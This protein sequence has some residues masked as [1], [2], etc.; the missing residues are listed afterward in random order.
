[1][2]NFFKSWCMKLDFFYSYSHIKKECGMNQSAFLVWFLVLFFGWLVGF[3]CLLVSD[4]IAA[5]SR[6]WQAFGRVTHLWPIFPTCRWTLTTTAHGVKEK[7][8]GSSHSRIHLFTGKHP[9]LTGNYL[10]HFTRTL[11]LCWIICLI[12]QTAE[13]RK[14]LHTQVAN[15]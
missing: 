11:T 13:P 4:K 6:V 8:D 9:L 14:F 10:L 15:I 12:Y 1:M 7:E 2:N 3:F 5:F